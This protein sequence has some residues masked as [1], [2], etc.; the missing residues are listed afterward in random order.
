MVIDPSRTKTGSQ[1]ESVKYRITA[2][3]W[4]DKESLD[5]FYDSKAH[6]NTMKM[7]AQGYVENTKIVVK[8][9]SSEQKEESASFT[10]LI[11]EAFSSE[12][13]Y[14]GQDSL[15]PFAVITE[16]NAS[17][18]LQIMGASSTISFE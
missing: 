8:D 12:H 15:S 14:L 10:K 17:V 4:A 11:D 2:S 6:L 1:N 5:K 16:E 7:Q 13:G 3:L 18:I 9:L